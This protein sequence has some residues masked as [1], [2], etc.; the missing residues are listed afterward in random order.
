[1]ER[2]KIFLG[3]LLVKE[4]LVTEGQLK[5]AL[6]EQKKTGEILG[7][8]LVRMNFVTEDNLAHLLSRYLDVEYVEL[9]SL[10][11]GPEVVKLIPDRLA[12]RYGVIPLEKKGNKLVVAIS[13]PQD[14]FVIDEL[15]RELGG[16]EIEPKIT[17]TFNINYALDKLYGSKAELRGLVNAVRE[18]KISKEKIQ[19]GKT[20]LEEMKD[21]SDDALTVQF[22]DRMLVDAVKDRASD[23]HIE[24][25]KE[26]VFV[27]FRIDGVLK[28]I[29]A[30]P[31]NIHDALVSRIKVMSNLDIAEKRIPQDGKF[32]REIDS[33]SYDVRV[34]TL[35]SIYGENVVMRILS[36]SSLSLSLDS[37]GLEGDDGVRF[38]TLIRRS[39]GIIFVTGPTGSGKTT[40][41]YTV[42]ES[43]K[44]RE[45]NIVTI[46]DPIEYELE[47]IV[48]SQVNVKANL[49]F[50]T[51]LRAIMRQ[52]P[53][54][55]LV[56]ETR[57]ME[58]AE[59]AIRAALTGHLVFSTLHT[60]DAP[61]AV[62]RLTDMGVEPFLIANST[63]GVIAQ[64]L[65]RVICP[66][67]KEK[68]LIKPE[69]AKELGIPASSYI[70]QGKGCENCFKTG[71]RGRLAVFE[72]FVIDE[73]IREMITSRASGVEVKKVAR[74]KGMRTLREAALDKALK[75][76]TTL[77]EVMRVTEK[78]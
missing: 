58:T 4:G 32:E 31:R 34:S 57:D 20:T 22:I 13:N 28:D 78:D 63:S 43:I 23:I 72:I 17:T 10:Q 48:Q 25:G 45:K 21:L 47:G 50:S 1:M 2:K 77:E 74:K 3:E 19:A 69:L 53:N 27:R 11:I 35:P 56:G 18:E 24:P 55:I 38:N 37:L 33:A 68:I 36:R 60:N 42:L 30:P 66:K 54:V 61:G 64:R 75:G 14:A 52:D 15:R 40:T 44:S 8:L 65:A 29:V 73:E 9:T 5:S 39:N 71:Y 62:T 67:C 26:F 6:D 46:E 7:A 51:L 76:I 12:R 49:T 16:T 70:Y 41:L 59:V